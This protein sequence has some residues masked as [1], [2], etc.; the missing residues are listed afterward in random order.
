MLPAKKNEKFQADQ[1]TT[2]TNQPYFDEVFP[3]SAERR[4]EL[5]TCLVEAA[6]KAGKIEGGVARKAA[7]SADFDALGDISFP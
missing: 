1:E 4:N 5:T 6:Q 2:K 7:P 3:L